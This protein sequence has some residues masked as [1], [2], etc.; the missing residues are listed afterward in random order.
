MPRMSPL[1]FAPF[2]SK[3]NLSYIPCA[4]FD[5]GFHRNMP[6]S[7]G[8]SPALQR[9]QCGASVA[10]DSSLSLVQVS[11]I[12]KGGSQFILL[13]PIIVCTAARYFPNC[14]ASQRVDVRQFPLPGA[15]MRPSAVY[16]KQHTIL[17][18]LRLE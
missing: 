10:K 13:F 2:A 17:L 5:S 11:G 12:K 9:T 14:R 16:A 3:C 7:T 4:I 15:G 18:H 6:P 8:C 1:V